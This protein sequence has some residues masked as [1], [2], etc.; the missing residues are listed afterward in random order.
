[1]RQRTVNEKQVNVKVGFVEVDA[2][3]DNITFEIHDQWKE[4]R[5][6]DPV[7][8]MEMDLE[9]TQYM[10]VQLA[11]AWVMLKERKA[12]RLQEQHRVLRRSMEVPD[13][14]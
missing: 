5:Q 2:G 1:M 3:Y 7:Y 12:K 10:I 8:V 11:R 14:S 13:V 9:R 4:D 6:K